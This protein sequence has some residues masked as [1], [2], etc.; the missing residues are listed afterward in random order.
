MEPWNDTTWKVRHE[1]EGGR[2]EGL[3][4]KVGRVGQAI[5]DLEDEWQEI[6]QTHTQEESVKKMKKNS[7]PSC[8]GAQDKS[9]CTVNSHNP[10][11]ASTG[12]RL[13]FQLRKAEQRRKP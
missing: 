7:E 11:S 13:T 5:G 1:D 10:C 8:S 9:F 4:R 3:L 2:G 12:R 6:T